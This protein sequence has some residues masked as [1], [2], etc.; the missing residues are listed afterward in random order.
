MAVSPLSLSKCPCSQARA[1][2]ALSLLQKADDNHQVSPIC[3][4]YVSEPVHQTVSLFQMQTTQ[5]K[6]LFL[7]RSMHSQVL[8]AKLVHQTFGMLSLLNNPLLVVLTDGATQFVVVHCWS[9][10]PFP[11]Q[12][13]HTARVFDLKD[14]LSLVD[15]FDAVA[16]GLGFQEEFLKEL[17]QVDR[18][19]A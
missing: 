11:P 3:L 1:K 4:R 7:I 8:W 9:V 16:E 6:R 19:F 14:T 18:V 17:P 2:T 5:L 10:L 15:P 12:T 13:C